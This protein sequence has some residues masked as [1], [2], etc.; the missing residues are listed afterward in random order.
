MK[1]PYV[2]FFFFLLVCLHS[3]AQKGSSVTASVDKSSIL[4]G[5][6][7]QL[8][9]EATFSN[10]HTPVFLTIDS[11]PHFEILNRSKIDTQLINGQTILKQTLTLTSWDSGA[12]LLPA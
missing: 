11:L 2:L 4:I 1:K 10:T 12:W 6:P 8:T 3:M 7:L 9:L 5:Q